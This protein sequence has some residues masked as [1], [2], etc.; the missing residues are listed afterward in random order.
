MEPSFCVTDFTCRMD[1]IPD[2]GVGREVRGGEGGAGSNLYKEGFIQ[3]LILEH[4]SQSQGNQG[5]RSLGQGR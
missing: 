3:L 1:R 2:R 4:G 5:G